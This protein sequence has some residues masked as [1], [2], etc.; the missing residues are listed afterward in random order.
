MFLPEASIFGGDAW[1]HFLLEG[2]LV[3]VG[4]GILTV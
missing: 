2:A 3:C 4:S 1:V